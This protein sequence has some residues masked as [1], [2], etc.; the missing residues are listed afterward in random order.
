MKDAQDHGNNWLTSIAKFAPF[1]IGAMASAALITK[2]IKSPEKLHL[3]DK[4][5]LITG[6]GR[7]LGI[8]LARKLSEYGATIIICGRSKETLREASVEFTS[9]TKRFM[10][11]P[12]DITDKDQI[13]EMIRKI[14]GE[15]GSVDVLINNAGIITVGP[16]ETMNQA[17]YE[18]AMNTHFWGPFNLIKE[19]LPDMKEKGRGNIVNIASIGS[20]VS[21]PH[22][23]PYNASKYALSGLSEGLAA[24][25]RKDNIKVTTVY[26]GLM[27]TGAPRNIDVKGQHKKEYGWFKILDSLPFLSMNAD[28]AA[29]KIIEALREEKRAFILSAPAKAA[30]AVQG[31]FPGCAIAAFHFIN[32]LLPDKKEAEIPRTSKGYESESRISESFLTSKTD[33]AARKN[34]EI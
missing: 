24:E 5:I 21:F 11:I 9:K 34:L 28:R 8:I 4:V 15:V 29:E 14:K 30:V 6:G 12:C 19:V 7:G 3:K 27:R 13:S 22:L 16:E 2:L 25:L 32:L 20:K 23:I 18:E 17:D 1:A 31:I 26:P 10:A 33:E